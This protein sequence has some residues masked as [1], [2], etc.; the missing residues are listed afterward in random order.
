[1][2]GIVDI[3]GVELRYEGIHCQNAINGAVLCVSRRTCDG[4]TTGVTVSRAAHPVSYPNRR[5]PVATNRPTIMAGADEPAT[6]SGLCQPMAI[7]MVEEFASSIQICVSGSD[8]T[9]SIE[10]KGQCWNLRV[11]IDRGQL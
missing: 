2:R 7:A 4:G 10:G 8:R 3:A 1:M 5:P 6:L 9:V 11:P